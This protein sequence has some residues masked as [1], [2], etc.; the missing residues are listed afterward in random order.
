MLKLWMLESR[1]TTVLKMQSRKVLWKRLPEI[2]FERITQKAVQTHCDRCRVRSQCL[3]ATLQ[4]NY[5]V[6]IFR[7]VIQ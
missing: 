3:V 1:H 6:S 4:K 2:P 7:F 5:F